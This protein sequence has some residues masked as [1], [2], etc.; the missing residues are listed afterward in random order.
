MQYS[1][2]NLPDLEELENLK[3]AFEDTFIERKDSPYV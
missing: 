3:K 1:L 2:N